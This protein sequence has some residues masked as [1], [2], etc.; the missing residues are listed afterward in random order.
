MQFRAKKVNINFAEIQYI[1]VT[2]KQ[3]KTTVLV[4]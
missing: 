4:M 2:A 3:Y 1:D